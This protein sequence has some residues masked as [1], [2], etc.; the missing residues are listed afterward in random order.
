M[1][2]DG[3]S[4]NAVCALAQAVVAAM[5]VKVDRTNLQ[6]YLELSAEVEHVFGPWQLHSWVYAQQKG[7][8][9]V[10]EDI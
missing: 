10:A 4:C 9:C 1:K 7:R 5:E 3:S 2:A 8:A 6:S